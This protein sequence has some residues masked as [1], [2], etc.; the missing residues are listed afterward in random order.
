M[1]HQQSSRIN[2]VP[3]FPSQ[4]FISLYSGFSCFRPASLLNLCSPRFAQTTYEPLGPTV[5]SYADEQHPV[6]SPDGQRLY[7]TRRG[8]SDN[9]GGRRDPGDIWYVERADDQSWSAAQHAGTKLNNAQYNGVV[10]FD[11]DGRMLVHGHYQPNGTPAR[12]QG[13][14]VAVP[15]GDGWSV[16][17]ALNIP[18]FYTKS[19]APQR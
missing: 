16:P 18:Y 13:L 4:E 11:R 3:T 2:H 19:E 8:H 17:E 10:G 6:V 1:V 14:S 15:S 12:T 9:V 5:N 7:F